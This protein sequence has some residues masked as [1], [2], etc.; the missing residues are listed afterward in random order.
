VNTGGF[1]LLHSAKKQEDPGRKK[2][3]DTKLSSQPQIP[4]KRRINLDK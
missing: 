2:P 3:V 4:P 1:F